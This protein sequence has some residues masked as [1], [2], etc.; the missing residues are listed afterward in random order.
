MDSCNFISSVRA[1]DLAMIMGASI[2][3]YS[4]FCRDGSQ[5][6]TVTVSGVCTDSQNGLDG[7]FELSLGWTSN[8]EILAKTLSDAMQFFMFI[9]DIRL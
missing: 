4:F 9:F 2:V 7:R 6:I 5:N 1:C 8:F 3:L